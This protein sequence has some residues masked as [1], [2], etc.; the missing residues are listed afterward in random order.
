MYKQSALLFLILLILLSCSKKENT[1]LILNR[2]GYISEELIV[3]FQKENKCKIIYD[4]YNSDKDMPNKMAASKRSY[5][6]LVAGVDNVMLFN[7]KTYLEPIIPKKLRNYSNLDSFVLGKIELID[8]VNEFT[9]PYFWGTHGLLYNKKYIPFRIWE[10]ESWNILSNSF[11]TD[12]NKITLPDKPK[13]VIGAALIT[14][15]YK[16]NDY[17]QEALEAAEGILSVWRSNVSQFDSEAYK[18][19]IQDGIT[20]LALTNNRDAA[21]IME[22]NPDLDYLLPGEGTYLWVDSMLIPK[23]AEHKEL[24]YKFIEFMLDANNS[25]INAEYVQFATPNK[26]SRL[27]L[28]DDLINNPILY[29]AD[30]YLSKCFM[31]NRN[32]E[33]ALKIEDLWQKIIK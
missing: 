3:K 31:L 9:I 7:K 33:N 17:S 21:Q 22:N 6:I 14:A 23:T 15:G 10:Q 18:S 27:L 5:D 16:P 13:E 24:A 25:K 4:T 20:W 32:E 12:K 8:E 29:P 28:S 2:T 11:F 26:A 30:D 19:E 1:L